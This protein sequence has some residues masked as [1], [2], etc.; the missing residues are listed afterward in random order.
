MI[1]GNQCHTCLAEAVF[2]DEECWQAAC[3]SC[4]ARGQDTGWATVTLGVGSH[5]VGG[6]LELPDGDEPKIRYPFRENKQWIEYFSA[7]ALK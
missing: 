4:G 7:E 5:V 3:Q 2:V 1:K 6:W